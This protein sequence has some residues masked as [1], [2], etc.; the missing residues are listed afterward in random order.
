MACYIEK[1]VL[2]CRKSRRSDG[3]GLA[4]QQFT[5]LSLCKERRS[6]QRP[7]RNNATSKVDMA[8]PNAV[9]PFA[10]IDVDKSCVVSETRSHLLMAVAALSPRS[11]SEFE[12][13]SH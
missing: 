2:H 7:S 9:A 1:D 8:D 5:Y 10:S 11:N 6:L 12:P 13:S 4:R 3:R